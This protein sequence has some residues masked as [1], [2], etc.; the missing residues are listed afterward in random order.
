MLRLLEIGSVEEIWNKV[1][2][3][4]QCNSAMHGPILKI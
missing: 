1:D 2:L 4:N 3:E